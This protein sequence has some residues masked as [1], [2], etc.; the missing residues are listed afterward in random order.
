MKAEVPQRNL[1]LLHLAQL[2]TFRNWVHAF[3]Q[4]SHQSFFGGKKIQ[5]FSIFSS[6]FGAKT[7]ECDQKNWSAYNRFGILTR[8]LLTYFLEVAIS[9]STPI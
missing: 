2:H 9:T 7:E 6:F 5:K 1:E 3:Q 4:S 8:Y